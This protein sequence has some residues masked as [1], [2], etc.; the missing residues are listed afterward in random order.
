MTDEALAAEEARGRT[1]GLVSVATVALFSAFILCSYFALKD[2]QTGNNAKYLTEISQNK[3]L[4]IAS[5]FAFAVANL[6]IALVLTHVLFAARQRSE[7]VP[8]FPLYVAIFG[9]LIVAVIYPAYT[10]AN[11]VAAGDFVD[12]VNQ[13]AE[14][15]RQQANTS[16]I[17]LTRGIWLV[18]QGLLTFAWLTTGLFGMR[19]GL[20]TR[21]VGTFAMAIGI[22]N[23]IAPPFAALLQV[24][25]VGAMA[26]MLI[27]ESA[28]VPPA[29]KL[30][31]P[32][33]WR[34]VD[35]MRAAAASED[36]PD[37]DERQ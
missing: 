18:G 10:L 27:G 9:P 1:V 25:W 31:R 32:V 36:T 12:A 17:E 5:G 13:T 2:A 11:V 28:Q 16:A 15:A 6:L 7:R 22:A 14:F 20:L 26:I 37:A 24:F 34:E 21:M 19:V 33:P 23:F 8:R 30:G 29:W 4:Y 35:A 3:G